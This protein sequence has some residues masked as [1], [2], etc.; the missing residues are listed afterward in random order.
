MTLLTV[1]NANDS[2]GIYAPA[3]M[4]QEQVQ[5]FQLVAEEEALQQV[6]DRNRCSSFVIA[7]SNADEAAVL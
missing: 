7:D 4:R 6:R 3:S 5:Q 2:L 1:M